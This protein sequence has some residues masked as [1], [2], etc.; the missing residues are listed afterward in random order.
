M[1]GVKRK[2]VPFTGEQLA[3]FPA[4]GAEGRPAEKPAAARRAPRC[5]PPQALRQRL[6]AVED[7]PGE[8]ATES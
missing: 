5:L 6:A 1:D 8:T 4:D 2:V 7:G 3:L